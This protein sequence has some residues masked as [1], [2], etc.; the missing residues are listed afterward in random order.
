[1]NGEELL[2]RE[3]G[4]HD[5]RRRAGDPR[6]SRAST[7]DGAPYIAATL[8]AWSRSGA[9]KLLVEDGG[10]ASMR[11]SSAACGVRAAWR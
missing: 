4:P 1:M 6:E 9:T 10:S 11:A 7:D 5:R 2:A 8:A 3:R